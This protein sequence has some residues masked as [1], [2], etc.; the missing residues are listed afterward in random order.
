MTLVRT[1]HDNG[2]KELKDLCFVPLL[3][4]SRPHPFSY[5]VNANELP[6]NQKGAPKEGLTHL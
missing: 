1:S 6:A 2:L 4:Y 5:R 3:I